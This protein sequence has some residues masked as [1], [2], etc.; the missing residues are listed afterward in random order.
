LLPSSSSPLS[1]FP[2]QPFAEICLINGNRREAMKYVAK[3]AP[4]NRY[5]L[6]MSME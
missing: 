2:P 3:A 4:E 5:K 6:Y 1:L